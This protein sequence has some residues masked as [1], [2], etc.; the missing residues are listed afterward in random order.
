MPFVFRDREETVKGRE[1][2]DLKALQAV[3]RALTLSHVG[4]RLLKWYLSSGVMGSDL[5]LQCHPGYL[6]ENV[7]TEA[8]NSQKAITGIQEREGGGLGQGGRGEVEMAGGCHLIVNSPGTG[9]T[10]Q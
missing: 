6:A 10:A 1:E 2:G 8:E 9:H 4:W 5:F 7:S 3:V